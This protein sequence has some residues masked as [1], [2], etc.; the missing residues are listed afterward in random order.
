MRVTAV[1]VTYGDRADFFKKVLKRLSEIPE[2]EKVVLIENQVSAESSATFDKLE[3]EFPIL[4]R[5]KMGYNSGSA[6]GFFEG[7][8]LALDN[9]AEFI[10]LLDDDNLPEPAAI[11]ELEKA[12]NERVTSGISPLCLLSYRPD[13]ELYKTAVDT[14]NPFAMLGLPNSFLG[15]SLF[16]SSYTLQNFNLKGNV[17]VAPYGGMFFHRQL[18][19]QIGFPDP[20]YYL[21]G[22][23]YDFS[24]RISEQGGGIFL[25]QESI[26]QDLETSFHLNKKKKLDNRY[27]KSNS[28]VQ[29]YYTVRNGIRFESKF[30]TNKLLYLFHAAIYLLLLIPMFLLRPKHLWK[31][32]PIFK[33]AWHAIIRKR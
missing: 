6:K 33:A 25:V 2:V 4:M 17:A 14:N 11:S 27:F 1:S 26:V 29:L 8:K 7:I 31:L 18:I 10:Y 21:Y 12:W 32:K 28:K 19:D 13:R 9:D 16:K 20:S 24:Y 23:D 22:D 15:F 30:V 3:R 5:H